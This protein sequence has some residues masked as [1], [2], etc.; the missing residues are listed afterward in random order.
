MGIKNFPKY[1]EFYLAL[2]E[3]YMPTDKIKARYHL[4][5]ATTL[6]ATIENDLPNQQEILSEINDERKKNGW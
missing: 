5:T 1:Y 6:L 3:L 2:Y 4:I